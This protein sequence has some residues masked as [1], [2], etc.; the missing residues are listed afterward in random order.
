[1]S[2]LNA[3]VLLPVEVWRNVISHLN[4]KPASNLRCQCCGSSN[5]V[6][7]N[8][9][10]VGLFIHLNPICLEC[11]DAFAE[12]SP[13]SVK[14]QFPFL[15]SYKGCSFQSLHGMNRRGDDTLNCSMLGEAGTEENRGL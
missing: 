5:A 15:N 4:Y 13:E 10:G 3:V 14:G 1:M 2:Q 7:P 8:I 12:S 6:L 11:W 9:H